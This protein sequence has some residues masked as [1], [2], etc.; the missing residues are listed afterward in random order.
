M[1][2]KVSVTIAV[3]NSVNPYLGHAVVN[4]VVVASKRITC[5]NAPTTV[6]SYNTVLDTMLAYLHCFS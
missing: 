3:V 4:D 5:H 6:S 1:H 2:Y